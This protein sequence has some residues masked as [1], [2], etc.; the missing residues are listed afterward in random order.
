ME[1]IAVSSPVLHGG[2]AMS[3]PP[4]APTCELPSA[5]KPPGGSAALDPGWDVVQQALS[6]DFEGPQAMMDDTLMS[7]LMEME[8]EPYPDALSDTWFASGGGGDNSLHGL[9]G[10]SPKSA[11]QMLQQL[12]TQPRVTHAPAPTNGLSAMLNDG[13]ARGGGSS[14]GIGGGTVGRGSG[15]DGGGSFSP[16]RIPQF[17]TSD[18]Q[19][20][21]QGGS[22]DHAG[23]GGGGGD[24]QDSA[25]SPPSG[26]MNGFSQPVLG[27]NG[28]ASKALAEQFRGRLIQALKFLSQV[29]AELGPGMLDVG[30]Q[31]AGYG[32][33]KEG[34]LA[35][36]WAPTV[37]G[38][39]RL[40]TTKEQPFSL[41][42][43]SDRLSAYRAVYMF[44]A[45]YL[46][47][48]PPGLPG[49]VFSSG[50]PEWSP[51]VQYYTSQEYLRVHHA[52]RCD[53]R[54][55]LAAPVFRKGTRDCVAVLELVMTGEDVRF[56]PRID[57]I[58]QALQAV[59]LS[60]THAFDHLPTEALP[61]Q[62]PGRSAVMAEILDVLTLICE[63]H[64]LPVAQTWL[65]VAYDPS[66]DIESGQNSEF[67]E[68]S[69][70]SSHPLKKRVLYTVD[71]P[72]CV[73]DL[74]MWGFRQACCEHKLEEGQ[75][76]PG[77]AI[78]SNQPSFSDDVKRMGKLQYPLGHFARKFGLGACVAI[79]L[80]SIF[81]GEDDY[82]LEFFL[83]PS[84][85]QPEK[86]QS[87]LNALS[88][89][90][91]QVCR[92]LRTVSDK[93]VKEEQEV[94]SDV[95]RRSQMAAAS[96]NNGSSQLGRHNASRS[97]GV[98]SRSVEGLGRQGC[99]SDEAGGGFAT[100]GGRSDEEGGVELEEN[101]GEEDEEEEEEEDDDVEGVGGTEGE[102]ARRAPNKW[103]EVDSRR[104]SDNSA[105]SSGKA[106]RWVSGVQQAGKAGALVIRKAKKVRSTEKHIT[107]AVLQQY[108]AGSLKDAAKSIGVCPTTLKRICRQH[109][110]SRWPSRKIKKVSQSIK[111]LQGVIQSVH[112]T[113]A[114][115]ATAAAVH[116]VTGAQIGMTHQ[117][118]NHQ[119]MVPQPSM[120][121]W[122]L[123][124]HSGTNCAPPDL[125]S[126]SGRGQAAQRGDED[127]RTRQ[128]QSGKLPIPRNPSLSS[129]RS[130][131]SSGD[132]G[133]AVAMDE[134]GSVHADGGKE[135]GGEGGGGQ[136]S[137][138]GRGMKS[139]QHHE[140]AAAAAGDGSGGGGGGGDNGYCKVHGRPSGFGHGHGQ[141]PPAFHGGAA[142][143]SV[144]AGAMASPGLALGNWQGQVSWVPA[145]P[146]G[147]VMVM[148]G[149]PMQMQA[150]RLS[151][152]PAY[153]A[154]HMGSFVVG[155][156]PPGLM[157]LESRVH[158]GAAA[159]SALRRYNVPGTGVE[160]RP[161]GSG[162]IEEPPGVSSAA[163]GDGL[164]GG[165][166]RPTPR[167]SVLRKSPSIDKSGS[168]TTAKNG[169]GE[170]A[171]LPSVGDVGLS[172]KG[173]DPPGDDG[174]AANVITIKATY[175][176]DTVR[177]KLPKDRIDFMKLKLEVA[178]RLHITFEG[179]TLKYF[180][181]EEEWM[182]L[183]TNSDLVEC[184]DVA[185]VSRGL[186]IKLMVKYEQPGGG[187]GAD[188]GMNWAARGGVPGGDA[189]GGEVDA[190]T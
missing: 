153:S 148:G 4:P 46:P 131:V 106:H 48:S 114:D 72:C 169:R 124:W 101:D 60:S 17:S 159:L 26:S 108:F 63:R 109:G 181:D 134:G 23:R 91:Q 50:R 68:F 142:A 66:A 10:V 5:A 172:P 140:G 168:P 99:R 43:G 167:G 49:R 27:L 41:T 133:L 42:N 102:S 141:G 166:R 104:N 79:R 24:I 190:E 130:P 103:Q 78:M 64:R 132:H 178:K 113:S 2:A 163:A 77:K 88:V 31:Q 87:L 53:V 65:A 174:S 175:G 40:L 98:A 171:G 182:L 25:R 14:G 58:C 6:A 135:A 97:S 162:P 71:G 121:G 127:G 73:S 54:G 186:P 18:L 28:L 21:D 9:F 157:A 136:Q 120:N 176:E 44:P 155:A 45:E 145:G 89:T 183:A 69:G 82:V 74:S 16:S 93:E 34:V 107:L 147:G 62:S 95:L 20:L 149:M 179:I 15:G 161:Y 84:C 125:P 126:T 22:L 75:G 185:R 90:M 137:G 3:P 139:Y 11:G 33:N 7:E 180:D 70:R 86:Q 8:M 96:N 165:R 158:G 61:P 189:E 67:G 151:G 59:E 81:T 35:Q 1:P 154:A 85:T 144:S 170:E 188:G 156:Y 111:R 39:R 30:L 115:I 118:V 164:G 152:F 110:I 52:Q 122:A 150:P 56:G 117:Q 94:L 123:P 32:N 57:N 100:G 177:F 146:P 116:A 184:M 112:G 51:N 29:F 143:G 92:S 119:A 128:N 105:S 83:P 37:Q 80:R 19:F 187:S 47:D 138:S 129:L 173:A 12:Q 160:L 36:I 13:L 38:N 55:T 76:C